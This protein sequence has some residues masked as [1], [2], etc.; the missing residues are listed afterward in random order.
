MGLRSPAGNNFDPRACGISV[1]HKCYFNRSS[2]F[3]LNQANASWFAAS[4]TA[5]EVRVYGADAHG[6]LHGNGEVGEAGRGCQFD[7][8]FVE[9]PLS[10]GNNAGRNCFRIFQ[11]QRQWS[12]ALRDLMVAMDVDCEDG[13]AP[14]SLLDTVITSG[15][16]ETQSENEEDFE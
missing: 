5:P 4:A 6:A 2:Q 16:Q 1:K 3:S 14:R 10:E 8:L 11:I 13:Q 9:D 12:T 15:I 7:P